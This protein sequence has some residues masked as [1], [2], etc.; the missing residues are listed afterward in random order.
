MLEFSIQ[1]MSLYRIFLRQARLSA[2][3]STSITRAARGWPVA[4]YSAGLQAKAPHNSPTATDAWQERSTASQMAACD[5]PLRAWRAGGRSDSGGCLG[6]LLV[7]AKGRAALCGIGVESELVE[8]Y[9]RQ[10]PA[11][12]SL[13]PARHAPEI[14]L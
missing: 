5:P 2:D 7:V 4:P 6:R 13:E 3:C 12:Q 11:M 9:G 1:I 8:G 14:Q 10:V